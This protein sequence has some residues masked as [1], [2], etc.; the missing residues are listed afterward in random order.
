MDK[1]SDD[2]LV[3]MALDMEMADIITLCSLSSRF[4]LGVCK[5]SNF[6][7]GKI[8]KDYNLN[9]GEVK[10]IMDN[11]R[12]FYRT[13]KDDPKFIYEEGMRLGLSDETIGVFLEA[14]YF[15][16]YIEQYNNFRLKGEQYYIVYTGFF[17][18]FR[19]YHES[20]EPETILM[21]NI[22]QMI[23]ADISDGEYE[24]DETVFES[25]HGKP[26]EEYIE[27]IRKQIY[28]IK[29]KNTVIIKIPR[30]HDP[31]DVYILHK[32]KKY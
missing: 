20:D 5:N 18:E 30:P 17:N 7:I 15:N 28:Q 6:W 23:Y 26:A 32:M 31:S 12:D 25:F 22:T 14:M 24:D 10:S 27:D 9:F 1:L 11:P 2:V 16:Q 21:S 13:L 3:Y 29:T 8:K 4:N 19:L